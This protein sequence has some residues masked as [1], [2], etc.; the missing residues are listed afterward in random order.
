VCKLFVV[1]LYLGFFFFNFSILCEGVSICN[2]NYM[3][4]PSSV[5]VCVPVCLM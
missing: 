2:Y 4:L 5:F 3:P 1:V